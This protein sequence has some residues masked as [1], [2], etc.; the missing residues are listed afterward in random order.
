MRVTAILEATEAV[1]RG[2]LIPPM[3]IRLRKRIT[4]DRQEPW[5]ENAY[6]NNQEVKG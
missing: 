3:D 2:S 1:T 4:R 5:T 6:L